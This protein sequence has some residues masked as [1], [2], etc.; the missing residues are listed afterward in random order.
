MH[1]PWLNDERDFFSRHDY[2]NLAQAEM[3][4]Q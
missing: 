4:L 2:D 3:M 1:T